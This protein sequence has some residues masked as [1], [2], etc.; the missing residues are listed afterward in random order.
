VHNWLSDESN[1]HWLLILD[2]ADDD[3]PFFDPDRPLERFVPQT[4]NG[5]LLITSRKTSAATNLVGSQGYVIEVKPMGEDDA[6][7]L[8]STRGLLID[9]NQI[10]SKALVQALEYIPLAITHAA[11]YIK[12]SALVTMADYIKRFEDSEAHLVNVLGRETYKDI[13]RDNSVRHAVIATWQIS[14]AQVQET[15]P[16]AADLLALMSM[17]DRQGIP[18]SLLQERCGEIFDLNE[19]LTVL[20]D[21]SLVRIQIGKESA[22]MHRL[23][24]LSMKA[25]LK[26]RQ[27]TPQTAESRG[28]SNIMVPR[29]DYATCARDALAFMADVYPFNLEN[30]DLSIKYLPHAYAVIRNGFSDS[31]EDQE[32]KRR[33]SFNIAVS[34]FNE[35]RW[36]EAEQYADKSLI[37]DKAIF[38]SESH[39][40]IR[41]LRLLGCIYEGQ[42]L[43]E[44]AERV[45]LE[46]M[47]MAKK[48]FGE[49]HGATIMTMTCLSRL[50]FVQRRY[51]KA[52]GFAVQAVE[53]S[54]KTFGGDDRLTLEASK[55]L[56]LVYSALGRLNEAEELITRCLEGCK[57]VYGDKHYQTQEVMARLGSI[58]SQQARWKRAEEILLQA[59][60]CLKDALGEDHPI[61]LIVMQQVTWVFINQ[62]RWAEAE[63]IGTRVLTASEMRLGERHPET[64]T[65]MQYLSIIYHNEGQ[66]ERSKE[67][68]IKALQI[69]REV[70][71]E[72]HPDVLARMSN[73]VKLSYKQD[74]EEAEK[75]YVYVEGV[76]RRVLGMDHPNTLQHMSNLAKA[77]ARRSKMREA[78]ALMK[79][80]IERQQRVLG[81][82]HPDTQGSIAW[83][84]KWGKQEACN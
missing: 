22:E 83:L 19:L 5:K 41:S 56:G 42:C 40:A 15:A 47:Q 72:E 59:T 81:K 49:L 53:A 48:C 37:L 32:A 8:L 64:L 24:Q 46:S 1:G 52:K 44:D 54:R 77:W 80:V 6:L 33:L 31:T 67:I 23:V 62:Q 13:R 45:L 78:V 57:K 29:L 82:D 30:R 26:D 79:E 9:S 69:S 20:V 14:F 73:L 74:N 4:P 3:G 51:E 12:A 17:F 2:N 58:Y 43:W 39:Y 55:E 35:G 27:T 34:L 38:G 61:A 75:A 76:A 18:L 28:V 60:S 21:F 50:Y 36:K 7:T 11:A 70:L 84:A 16:T 63:R 25:W 10:D 65:A 66:S 68:L 71:G